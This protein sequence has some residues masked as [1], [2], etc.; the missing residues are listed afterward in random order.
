MPQ[1]FSNNAR[2][3]LQSTI[4]DTAT[5][6]T[7]ASG[8]ADLFPT[9]NV[10]TGSI[11]SINNWFK[12]TLQDV[13]GNVEIIYV[14]TRNAGSAVFSN[15]LRGQEGTIARTFVAGSAVGLRVTAVDIQASINLPDANTT[16]SGANTFSQ[17]LSL[18]QG[19]NFGSD[20]TSRVDTGKLTVK[21]NNTTIVDVSPTG[22]ITASF[23]GPL[24]G[25]VTGNLTGNVTGKLLT[26]NWSFEQSGSDLVALYNG[27]RRFKI[28]SAGDL[29]VS[30]NVTAYGT[31]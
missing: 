24:V 13:S 31:V 2:S 30:G 19:V 26:A 16:Y 27:A 15:I 20:F 28:T 1:Q 14:R 9:A 23:A 8:A 4:N 29:V 5:S 25:N 18:P 6:L 22:V 12:A 10:G 3:V 11:P 7:I 21:Y 17:A